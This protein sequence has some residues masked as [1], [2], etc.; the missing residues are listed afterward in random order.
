MSDLHSSSGRRSHSGHMISCC[1]RQWHT[2]GTAGGIQHCN[3]TLT[4]GGNL[5]IW[6]LINN[7]LA[8]LMIMYM[9]PFGT[10]NHTY[11]HTDIPSDPPFA[12]WARTFHD[13]PAYPLTVLHFKI[14]HYRLFFV[15][16]STC[17]LVNTQFGLRNTH[18][19]V[20]YALKFLQANSTH[21]DVHSACHFNFASTGPISIKRGE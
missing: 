10:T 21:S 8:L 20:P 1:C 12:G 19:Q 2:P 13:R 11:T 3:I 5:L 15:A 9:S 4:S 18:I 6:L 14:A 16:C 17:R 7:W